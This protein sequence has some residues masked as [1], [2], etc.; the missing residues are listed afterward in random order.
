[1][2]QQN[3]T[4]QGTEKLVHGIHQLDDCVAAQQL[5]AVQQ[6]GQAGAYHGLVKPLNGVQTAQH[7]QDQRKQGQMRQS[8]SGCSRNTGGHQI[9]QCHQAGFTAAVCQRAA[10]QHSSKGGQHGQSGDAAVQRGRT[11][12]PQQIQRQRK[13]QGGIAEQGDDL[14]EDDK[15]KSVH[16]NLLLFIYRL[17][18]CIYIQKK[19][20]R[21][22]REIQSLTGVHSCT[23][24]SACASVKRS[25]PSAW[26]IC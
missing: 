21:S 11:S 8:G 1:M 26:V 16:G 18:V 25:S 5:G 19:A 2:L 15:N 10:G 14:P 7:C 13:P 12:L 22:A 6:Q 3:S 24:C 23:S 17:L 9:Q 4:Q 20:E